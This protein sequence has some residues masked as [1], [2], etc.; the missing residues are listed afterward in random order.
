MKQITF[1]LII[2]VFCISNI[3]AQDNPYE[4]FGYEHKVKY[5]TKISDYLVI[6]NTDTTCITKAIA[7]NM[8]ERYILFL[9]KK[10]SIL[11]KRKIEPNQL[12]RWL[13]I[14]PLADKY[15][16]LAPYTFV[17]NT[18]INAIDPDGRY[19]IFINGLRT[20]KGNADQQKW[21]G[22][23][24]IHKTDVYDYWRTGKGETNAFG[25]SVDLV[26]YFQNKYDD[27][28]IGFTSGSSHWNS[29]ASQRSNEGVVKA[30]TFH[31]MVQA[32]DITLKAGETIKI[33]SHS[34]GGAHSAGYAKKLMSYKDAKGNALYNVEI[35]EYITPHQPTDI[36]HPNGILGI[37]YSHPSDAVSSKAPWWMPN[38]GSTYGH[39]N[40]I[41]EFYGGDI[42]G[43][44]GQ[45]PLTG[46]TGN[47]NGHNVTDND[48]FIKKSEKQ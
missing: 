30:E 46:A 43:G 33:I 6:K 16:S 35:I 34:Q 21:I 27:T 23:G 15:P 20:S 29:Q 24:R 11:H 45:P 12:L 37:Q 17:A 5:E 28:N 22:G 40:N 48:E 32:G 47:R 42:M 19:I 8:D 3:K 18:P 41:N 7:F 10:D 9:D 36:N 1:L 13:S 44:K 14:D 39:I 25:R 26:D 31:N 2:F 38:G 4:I